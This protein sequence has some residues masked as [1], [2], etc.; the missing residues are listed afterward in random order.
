MVM[1][2]DFW[3]N[4]SVF[5]T[6]H[7]GFKG[8][9]TA[10]LLSQ[11]GA[12]VFGYSLAPPTTP[13]FFVETK[14]ETHLSNSKIANILDLKTLIQ[15]MNAAKPS[16]VIHMAAQPLVRKSYTMPVDTFTTNVI[17]TVNTLEAARQSETVKAVIIVTSDKCYKNHE[18][19]IPYR[20]NDQLGGHD[21]YSSS[22]AC[23]ELVTEAYQKSFYIDL[24]LQLASVRAGNVIGGGDWAA[25]RLIPD[26]FRALDVGETLQVRS[27][28]AIRPWQHVLEPVFGYLALAEKLVVNDSSYSEAWNF[29][30]EKEDNKAVSWIVERL[31]NKIS[32]SKWELIGTP[33]LHEA[34]LLNLDISKSKSRLNWSPRWDLTKALD[35]TI[36]WHQAWKQGKSMKEISINQIKSYIAI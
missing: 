25:D 3:K 21:P 18:Q 8:G 33:H 24:G 15:E 19:I 5:L 6:G 36:D 29:G 28:N 23:A 1:N 13:S 20:E 31:C 30:P 32:G 4:R 12:N 10:L 22:K 11:M 9:W 14:L 26:F 34:G 27:P 35:M 2:P 7:T 17:G 16:I